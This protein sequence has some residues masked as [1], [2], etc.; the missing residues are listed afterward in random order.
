MLCRINW[1]GEGGC[2]SIKLGLR[3]I[4]VWYFVKIETVF[5]C[6]NSNTLKFINSSVFIF[7]KPHLLTTTWIILSLVLLRRHIIKCIRYSSWLAE[8]QFTVDHG[9]FWNILYILFRRTKFDRIRSCIILTIISTMLWINYK[10]L[11]GNSLNSF[12]AKCT[13]GCTGH[14]LV[15]LILIKSI[16]AKFCMTFSKI[17]PNDLFQNCVHSSSTLLM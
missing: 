1:W 7:T 3:G 11:C 9:K 8:S 13:R 6:R 5:G 4:L 15:L 10:C 16:A 12:A 17:K 2:N 14:H